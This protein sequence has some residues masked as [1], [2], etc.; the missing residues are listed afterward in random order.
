M[1]GTLSGHPAIQPASASVTFQEEWMIR[2]QI[3]IFSH[4]GILKETTL[5]LL[6]ACV[7]NH[8]TFQSTT[9]FSSSRGGNKDHRFAQWKTY[10]IS[11]NVIMQIFRQMRVKY[12]KIINN[13]LYDDFVPLDN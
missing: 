7:W 6:I 8:T 11:L 10:A 5:K 9:F 1:A 3:T 2:H 13:T 12:T 4:L